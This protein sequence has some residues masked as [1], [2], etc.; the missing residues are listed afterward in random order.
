[1]NRDR[2]SNQSAAEPQRKEERGPKNS[3]RKD[4]G[5]WTPDRG[6]SKREDSVDR[7]GKP[8][9]EVFPSKGNHWILVL[10]DTNQPADASEWLGAFSENALVKQVVII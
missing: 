2:C 1:M 6:K 5:N 10:S 9:T 8:G 3:G 7:H 4:S